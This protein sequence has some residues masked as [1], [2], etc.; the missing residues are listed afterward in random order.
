MRAAVF[1]AFLALLPV[2]ASASA[3]TMLQGGARSPQPFGPTVPA[4]SANP[5]PPSAAA[6]GSG[7]AAAAG[8]TRD[9][10]VQRAQERAGRAAAA[11]FDQIDTNH[12]G[13]A[14]PD[15]LKAYRAQ[16]RRS[17]R[18]RPDSNEQ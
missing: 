1:L 4:P 10:Y 3:Q 8:V 12:D 9:E 13:I 5:A 17:S 14:S 6:G 16:H 2:A 7:A 15:E 11:R 18:T